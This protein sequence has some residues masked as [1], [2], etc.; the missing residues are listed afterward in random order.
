MNEKKVFTVS[1][2][3]KIPIWKEINNF[4]EEKKNIIYDYSL[5]HSKDQFYSYLKNTVY[6]HLNN[7]TR[8]LSNLSINERNVIPREIIYTY[9]IKTKCP[10]YKTEII[11]QAGATKTTDELYRLEMISKLFN[12]VLPTA[13]S[14]G[15]EL[16]EKLRLLL[17]SKKND[18]LA[19]N[20]MPDTK[21]IILINSEL[22][23]FKKLTKVVSDWLAENT[24]YASLKNYKK[25]FAPTYILR[26]F[27]KSKVCEIL[28]GKYYPTIINLR[29]VDSD[30]DNK[31]TDPHTIVNTWLSNASK[32]KF[33]NMTELIEFHVP[34]PNLL[35]YPEKK[36]KHDSYTLKFESTRYRLIKA[37]FQTV[38]IVDEE[39]LIQLK[40][41]DIRSWKSF[42]KFLDIHSKYNFYDLLTGEI[43]TSLDYSA[44][45]INFHHI[46]RDK[47]NDNDNNLCFLLKKNH[48]MI[49]GAEKYNLELKDFFI[50][51]LKSNLISIEKG[52]IPSS[53]KFSWREIAIT[54]GLQ[55]PEKYYK[56]SKKEIVDNS[57]NLD[58]F[59]DY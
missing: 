33:N 38:L 19:G 25:E 35:G 58:S 47:Q 43:I 2:D 6:N 54:S 13:Y 45:I 1:Y 44:A 12:I 14:H 52:I 34:N 46:D 49:T 15:H 30:F 31:I 51:I 9:L 28:N 27:L 53:W 21:N 10:P 20:F 59:L 17:D 24:Q 5:T 26:E 40:S 56:D 3:R 23:N 57:Y 39:N 50:K 16:G 4:F 8:L 55:L 32:G 11:R 42:F 29:K 37:I 7:N 22:K 48:S 18:I 41:N 36:L